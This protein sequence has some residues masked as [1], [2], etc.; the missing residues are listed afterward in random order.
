M[1]QVNEIEEF[2]FTVNKNNDVNFQSKTEQRVEE[3]IEDEDEDEME[4]SLV[5]LPINMRKHWP[6]RQAHLKPNILERRI[7]E[8]VC[9]SIDIGAR[10]TLIIDDVRQSMA[11][12]IDGVTHVLKNE[13]V[14]DCDC[15][16]GKGPLKGNADNNSNNNNDTSSSVSSLS[17]S[18]SKQSV[19]STSTSESLKTKANKH[20]TVIL[21]DDQLLNYEKKVIKKHTVNT[22]KID[23]VKQADSDMIMD[24]EFLTN[25]ERALYERANT[26]DSNSVSEGLFIV[27]VDVLI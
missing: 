22:L 10:E 5:K 21:V 2:K 25:S 24:S 26:N 23:V 6:K 18:P 14:I 11:L 9:N 27:N 4:E 8:S 1:Y 20:R 13:F 7:R 15:N 17:S 3:V 12:D 16:G 19:N